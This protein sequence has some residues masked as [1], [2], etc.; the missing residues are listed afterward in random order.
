MIQKRLFIHAV[1]VTIAPIIVAWYGLSTPSAV[2][3]V[4]L[5]LLWRWGVVLSGLVLPPKTPELVL[6]TISV[7]HFV[8]KVRWSMDRLG[9]DYVEQT[10]GGTLGAFFRGRTVPQLKVRT[11]AVQSVIGNSS[12][13]LRYLWGRYGHENPGKAEFLRPTP[14]R[15]ELERRIDR[16]GV[17][18]QV[19][20]YYHLLGH[21]DLTL[22]A[23]GA[24]NPETPWWQR[25]A[26]R[27]LYPVLVWLIRKSFRITD[28]RYQVARDGI[29]GLLDETEKMLADEEQ[30]SLLGGDEPNYTDFAFAAMSGPWL[31]PDGYAA[32]RANAVRLEPDQTPPGMQ[33]D[34]AAWLKA[35]PASV[36]FIRRLYAEQRV[37]AAE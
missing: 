13:I 11:G 21:R 35:Y 10:S 18:L 33:D 14:E 31:W 36:S 5:L 15:V 1:F 16:Y 26:L 24:N 30:A 29:A 34:V 32:G 8:E 9:V 28:A 25:Q 4:L 3:L 37:A 7:S 27:P 6:A 17:N 19:W 2:L 20:I 22:Q 12:E 23:W